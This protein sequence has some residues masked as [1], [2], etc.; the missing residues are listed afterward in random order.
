[1][2]QLKDCCKTP[3]SRSAVQLLAV[4]FPIGAFGK[5]DTWRSISYLCFTTIDDC[6]ERIT[7]KLRGKT[8]KTTREHIKCGRARKKNTGK[9]SEHAT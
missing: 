8:V 5:V 6:A 2:F 1:M 7:F 3:V 9:A 4:A